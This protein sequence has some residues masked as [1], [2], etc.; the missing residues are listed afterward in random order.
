MSLN[1]K[2]IYDLLI[3]DYINVSTWALTHIVSFLIFHYNTK[4][5]LMCQICL[6]IYIIIWTSTY[7]FEVCILRIVVFFTYNLSCWKLLL[8]RS[9]QIPPAEIN[10]GENPKLMFKKNHLT[11]TKKIN[12][13]YKGTQYLF[14]Y[15]ISLHYIFSFLLFYTKS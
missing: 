12:L 13:K 10:W 1:I 11:L 5:S 3:P 8:S 15:F 6:T 9:S 4:I 7:C 14:L 2:C